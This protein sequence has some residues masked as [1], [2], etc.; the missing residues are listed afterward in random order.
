MSGFVASEMS[1]FKV[2]PAPMG[3]VDFGDEVAGEGGRSPSPAHRPLHRGLRISFHARPVSYPRRLQSGHF[4]RYLNR[5]YHVLTTRRDFSVD[6]AVALQQ[7][8][9]DIFFPAFL[10]N[11]DLDPP[12]NL[13]S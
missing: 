13:Q 5:T 7:N 9:P 2:V 10:R 8:A 11:C 1:A 12:N 6:K 3:W 4:M